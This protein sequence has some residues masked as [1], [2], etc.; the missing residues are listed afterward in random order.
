MK[1]VMHVN[2]KSHSHY[3]NVGI[4][5]NVLLY[6]MNVHVYSTSPTALPTVFRDAFPMAQAETQPSANDVGPP[7][8]IA[9][10]EP[11]QSTFDLMKSRTQ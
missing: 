3:R 5:V 8:L 2:A 6:I 7:L 10:P 11:L 9:C 4:P 1:R